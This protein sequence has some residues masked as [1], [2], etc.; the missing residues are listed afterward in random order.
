MKRDMVRVLQA[1]FAQNKAPGHEKLILVSLQATFAQNKGPWSWEVNLVSL[2][3]TF[4]K[5][6]EG[7]VDLAQVYEQLLWNKRRD[8]LMYLASLWATFGQIKIHG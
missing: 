6:K 2:W 8:S 1:T 7:L 4:A 3:E 5:I